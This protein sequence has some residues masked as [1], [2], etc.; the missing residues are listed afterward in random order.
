[1][2]T[3][4]KKSMLLLLTGIM[5]LSVTAC[6][7]EKEENNT[8]PANSGSG[9]L[10][11]PIKLRILW[12]GSQS[13]HDATIKALDLYSKQ[14]PNVTFE[15]EY[16]GWDGYWDKLSTQSAAKNSPDIIQMDAAYLAEY[17]GRN[18]L[19]D[20]SEGIHTQDM[21]PAL[22]DSGKYKDQLYAIALGNNAYG[23]AY[24]K[25]AIEKL[26]IKMPQNGWTWDDYFNMGREAKAKL[27]PNKYALPDNSAALDIY[28]VYQLSK[29]KGY[30]VTDE[31]KFNIDKTTWIDWQKRYADLRK[32]GVVPTPDV[33]V[34]DKELDPK[35][36]LMANGTILIRQ[37]HAAQ[38]VAVDG[39]MPNAIGMVTMPRDKEPAGWLKSSMFWS[40]SA[41]SKYI[42]ESKKFIDWFINNKEAADILGSTRGVPV[43]KIVLSHV[44]P[45]FSAADKMGVELINNTAKA[46]QIFHP[47]P[48]G[49]PNFRQKDYKAIAEKV[50]F[51]KSTPEQAYD[52][53]VEKAK[54]Y[55]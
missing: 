19:A 50:T 31:G 35:M 14:N 13:R 28:G 17:A 40:V 12:W 1:M 27:G 21:S 20:L 2:K 3:M 41:D 11:K 30:Y 54:E 23:M 52:E 38:S 26:G 51:G 6:G 10:N 44:E 24:N 55:E 22:V 18:Q 37:M 53:L 9:A 49:W 48:K 43:S 46:A 29:G 42:E 36:D 25:V 34:T 39:L 16:S 7:G 32:E 5:A 4:W 45:K 33:T 8:S 47:D 15:P